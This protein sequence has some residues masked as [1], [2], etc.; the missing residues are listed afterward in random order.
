M[1]CLVYLVSLG[2]HWFLLML[3]KGW[4]GFLHTGPPGSLHRERESQAHEVKEAFLV[5]LL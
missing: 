5:R 2:P 4:E 3:P 1:V